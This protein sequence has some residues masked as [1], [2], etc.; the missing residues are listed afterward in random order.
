M[1]FGISD[2]EGIIH[3]AHSRHLRIYVKLGYLERRKRGTSKINDCYRDGNYKWK[4]NVFILVK[5]GAQYR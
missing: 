1:K 3:Q 5:V 2:N 4:R